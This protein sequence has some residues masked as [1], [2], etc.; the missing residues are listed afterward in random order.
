WGLEVGAGGVLAGWPRAASE[1]RAA[2][3]EVPP[4][5]I[6]LDGSRVL[7]YCGSIPHRL[8]DGVA[9]RPAYWVKGLMVLPEYSRGPIGFLVVKQL[10][11]QLTRATALVVAPAARRLFSALGYTDLGAVT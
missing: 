6:V 5:A 10:A 3:G 1:N 11:T 8:W 2:P 7:G 9:E 4:V